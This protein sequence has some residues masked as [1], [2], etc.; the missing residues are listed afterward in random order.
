MWMEER[1]QGKP[2]K[3]GEAKEAKME[4]ERE[5]PFLSLSLSLEAQEGQESQASRGSQESQAILDGGLRGLE[6][7]GGRESLQGP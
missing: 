6:G 5:S 7:L 3:P 4:G 2:R 1:G